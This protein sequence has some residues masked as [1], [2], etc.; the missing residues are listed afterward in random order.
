M[1]LAAGIVVLLLSNAYFVSSNSGLRA[2][3]DE[4]QTQLDRAK[5]DPGFG[6]EHRFSIDG[7]TRVWRR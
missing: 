4:L 6:G 5:G 1:G 3:M 7:S 2:E